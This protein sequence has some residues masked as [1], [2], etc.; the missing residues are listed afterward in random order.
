MVTRR[1]ISVG[2]LEKVALDTA[3]HKTAKRLRSL[4]DT[5]EVWP[6]GPATLQHCL[7]SRVILVLVSD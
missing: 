5:S 1:S 6:R 7:I 3:D 2:K 4:D